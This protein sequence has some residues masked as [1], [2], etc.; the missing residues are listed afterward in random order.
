MLASFCY[1]QKM[2]KYLDRNKRTPGNF[3]IISINSS[4]YFILA[5][6]FIYLIGQFATAIAAM[7][8]DYTGVI[9]YYKL[10]YTIDSHSWMSDAV[11]LLFSLP[12][13][14]ALL[15]A[16][17]SVIAFLN[18][19]ANKSSFKLFF[20]WTFVHG[21][22]WFFGAMLVG[23]LLD[24]GFGF[25]ILYLYFKDTGKLIL[26]LLSL[27]AMLAAIGFTTKWF[28]FSANSYFNQLNEHSRT[29]FI[30]SQVLFPILAGTFILIGIKLP[31]INIY[32]LLVLGTTLLAMIPIGLS[33]NSYP[34]F[35][36]DEE[37][38]KVK[39]K[40]PVVILAIISLVG[41]RIIFGIGIPFGSA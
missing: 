8:F 38:I 5:F 24:S 25:V 3:L 22:V 28:I 6:L 40:W 30:F 41:F 2:D 1:L 9:Y 12:P 4:A 18:M 20:L 10:I 14:T 37:P 34:T 23:T 13:V 26:S 32:E 29:F 7:Q 15:I 36:F 33:Y 31:K 11:K 27:A 19:Y 16:M 35:F 39:M 17:V 21:M